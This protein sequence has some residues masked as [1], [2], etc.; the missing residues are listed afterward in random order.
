MVLG[1]ALGPGLSGW[2]IDQGVSF[3]AQLL[4]YGLSFVFAS[5]VMV[6][7]LRAATARLPR[8]A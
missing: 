8:S 4:A 7:P 5:A 2:L 6:V 1:S 3:P